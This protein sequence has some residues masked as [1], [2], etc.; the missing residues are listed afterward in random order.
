MARNKLSTPD[1]GPIDRPSL[2]GTSMGAIVHSHQDPLGLVHHSV[3]RQAIASF[4]IR[5]TT[6]L[7]SMPAR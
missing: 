2:S 5:S 1:K 4:M 7:K 6:S 3:C